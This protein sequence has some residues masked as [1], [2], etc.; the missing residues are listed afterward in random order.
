M[1]QQLIVKVEKMTQEGE[2]EGFELSLPGDLISYADIYKPYEGRFNQMFSVGILSEF[3]DPQQT[4]FMHMVPTKRGY[5]AAKSQF[6]PTIYL[7]G[8]PTAEW[9]QRFQE[10]EATNQN[11]AWMLKPYNITIGAELF[12]YSYRERSGYGLGLKYVTVSPK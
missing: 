11:D 10:K 4:P 5:F 12:Y 3:V 9:I 7:N 6:V 2:P 1:G 8:V